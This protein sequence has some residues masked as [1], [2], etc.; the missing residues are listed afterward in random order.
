M[1]VAS[2]PLWKCG[3]QAVVP[4]GLARAWAGVVTECSAEHLPGLNQQPLGYGSGEEAELGGCRGSW[5]T[6]A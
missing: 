5:P 3:V 2:W 1:L 6:L 4:W